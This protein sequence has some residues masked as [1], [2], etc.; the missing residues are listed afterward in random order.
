MIIYFK[1]TRD[2]FGINLREQGIFLLL[3]GT[4]TKNF[5]EQWNLLIGNKGEKVKFSRD[6]GNM[7]PRVPGRSSLFSDIELL[8]LM[9]RELGCRLFPFS[10]EG[11]FS[12]W[13][14]ELDVCLFFCSL[15]SK[16]QSTMGQF[17]LPL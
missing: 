16:K 8:A 6:Q 5:G 17:F 2:I 1:G 3:K 7:L 11:R 9:T 12:V 4:L 10:A 13:R 15:F 14:F